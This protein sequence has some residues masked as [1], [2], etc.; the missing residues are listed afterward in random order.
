MY[1]LFFVFFFLCL[2]FCFLS[3]FYVLKNKNFFN[4][5]MI[6]GGQKGVLPPILII[7]ECVPGLPP[8]V[9]AYGK[10]LFVSV[11]CLDQNNLSLTGVE[12]GFVIIIVVVV[13]IVIIITIIIII[14]GS[15]RLMGVIVLSPLGL[16]SQSVGRC[17][18]AKIRPLNHRV[19]VLTLISH[20]GIQR[21]AY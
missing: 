6:I 20:A 11:C 5:R 12:A 1:S 7:G 8:K 16:K 15:L 14:A 19:V 2:C 13:I 10:E 18:E 3:C 21:L 17:G 9:Y 4:S